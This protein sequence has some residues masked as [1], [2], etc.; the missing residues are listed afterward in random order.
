MWGTGLACVPVV[1]GGL[2]WLRLMPVHPGSVRS[3]R[4]KLHLLSLVA[5]LLDQPGQWGETLLL[6]AFYYSSRLLI[7]SHC[8]S[9]FLVSHRNTSVLSIP[10]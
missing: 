10:P 1:H 5:Q 4:W 2:R 3:E 9:L 8:P 7:S 6:S